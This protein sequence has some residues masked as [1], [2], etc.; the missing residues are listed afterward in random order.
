[1]IADWRMKDQDGDSGIVLRGSDKAEVQIGSGAAANEPGKWNRLVITMKGETL[2][3]VQNGRTM[4]DK[5]RMSGVPS[6]GRIGLQ[7]GGYPI[8]FANL[9]IKELN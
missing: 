5:A 7:H 4:T 6:R 8:E 2:T 3:V 9:Y 1:M